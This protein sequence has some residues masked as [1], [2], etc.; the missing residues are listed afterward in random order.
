MGP[1]AR[2]NFAIVCDSA[3]DL[4]LSTL[5]R[6][7][8]A[9]VPLVVSIG[10]KNY[11]DCIDLNAADYFVSYS[12]AKGRINTF[13]PAEGEFLNVYEALVMQGYTEIVSVHLSSAMRDA[14]EIA[15]SAARKVSG[16]RIQVMDTKGTSGKC[17]L[18]LA[19]LANDRD[20]GVPVDE[21]V[22]RAVRVAE[23]AH[24]LLVPAYD[25]KP[26][27]GVG[28]KRGGI[29]GHA[30]SLQRRALGMRSV[31]EI[32]SDGR[33]TELFR[34]TDLARLAGSMARTMSAHAHEVGPLTYVEVSAGVPRS[35]AIIEK[36]LVTN[37]FE[38]T[39]AAVLDS[40]PSTTNQVG[41]GA[42]GIAYVASKLLSPEEAAA[43]LKQ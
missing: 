30:G 7:G 25:A 41:V 36:P 24:M 5:E 16:A 11:R 42:V 19:R 8:I 22:T 37:E 28:H 3:C 18:V 4:P 21:A 9:L 20:A 15:V 39:R 31:F 35:L 10:G 6:A 17:A 29:L 1:E 23:E 43:V 13:S 32:G 38:S 2:K 33:A 34:S 26:L 40:N 27:R 14:Y 12:T